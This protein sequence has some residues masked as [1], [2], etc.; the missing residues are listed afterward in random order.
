MQFE[1]LSS[2]E[3]KTI[4]FKGHRFEIA[5]ADGMINPLFDPAIAE[6]AD[7]TKQ[8]LDSGK[9]KHEIDREAELQVTAGALLVG[10]PQQDD[11]G[12]LVDNTPESRLALLRKYPA[13]ASAVRRE[14]RAMA[15]AATSVTVEED[16]A[17]N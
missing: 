17:K 15:I 14:S 2:P 10:L 13:L 9:P 7:Y 5:P 16:A 12:Q 11:S 3:T 4:T 8:Q 1:S 6:S